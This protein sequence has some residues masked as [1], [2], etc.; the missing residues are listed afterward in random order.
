MLAFSRPDIFPCVGRQHKQTAPHKLRKSVEH[1][2]GAAFHFADRFH[3]RVHE[4]GAACIYRK[5]LEIVEDRVK[6]VHYD[7][8]ADSLC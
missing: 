4:Q 3:G 1:G 6:S 2:V 7:S 8:P 5:C